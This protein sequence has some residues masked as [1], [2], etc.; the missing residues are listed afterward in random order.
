MKY[1]PE[2]TIKLI[3]D[4]RSGVKISTLSEN[5]GVPTKSI[6][7]KLSSLGVYQKKP[8][9]SKTGEV[10]VS[11]EELLQQI[12]ELTGESLEPMESLLKS[13]KTVLKKIIYHLT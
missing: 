2:I 3:E 8:Y 10:P 9:L 5:L 7:A 6:I 1:T 4:Y 11:K 13:N 12:C